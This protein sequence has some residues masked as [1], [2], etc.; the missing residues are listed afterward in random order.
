MGRGGN[1][2]IPS[3]LMSEDLESRVL[4][5]SASLEQ[6]RTAVKRMFCRL[7]SSLIPQIPPIA[8]IKAFVDDTS[9]LP[10]SNSIP[11]TIKNK[12]YSADV[13]FHL[14][15]YAHWDPLSTRRVPAVIFVW[16]RGQVT[17]FSPWSLFLLYLTPE[18]LLLSFQPLFPIALCR[19]RFCA[20]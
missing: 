1:A 11:W 20:V 15:E 2:S 19:T 7:W 3:T 10:S 8:V 12:Y 4:V 17:L 9:E 14:I 18:A 6:A 5:I 13:H 16:A